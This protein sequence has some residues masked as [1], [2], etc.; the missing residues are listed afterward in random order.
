MH[1]GLWMYAW[2]LR[3]EGLDKVL[4]FARDIGVKAVNLASSYHA[5]FF[6]HPHNP[7]HKMYFA[8]DGVVYFQP[9]MDLYRKTKLKPLVAEVSREVDWFKEVGENL[10]KFGLKLIAW[11]VCL[12]N[13]R[14]GTLHPD[15]TVRNIFGDLYP[16]ALCPSNE[17]VRSYI[18]ALCLDLATHYPLHAIQLEAPGF[19]GIPHGHH[20]ERY[21]VVL[22]RVEQELLSLCFCN[23]CVKK[24]REEG[25]NVEK[26][27]R[28]V[29]NYLVKFFEKTPMKPEESA[30]S[31]EELYDR[32]PE[33]EKFERF[34]RE[35]EDSLLQEIKDEVGSLGVK[36]FLLDAYREGLEDVIDAFYTSLYGMNPEKASHTIREERRRTPLYKELHAG[37]SLCFGHIGKPEDLVQI[38]EAV[39]REENCGVNFYNYSEAP[40][41][42]LKWIKLCPI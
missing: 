41:E 13:T 24:S 18:K 8:L 26:V 7:T 30:S 4:S 23:R 35:A 14:L 12:H 31:M 42:K 36:L 21:G 1:S 25:V 29:K 19:M 32:E 37:I 33:L 27:K 39:K 34:R 17:S 20:H 5:G 11:T 22:G 40:M 2:D 10:D 28:T 3:D 15:C 16:H 38:V 9:R 6:L